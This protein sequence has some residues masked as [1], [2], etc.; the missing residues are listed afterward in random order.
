[1]NVIFTVIY[2]LSSLVALGLLYISVY[3][4]N[5]ERTIYFSFFALHTFIYIAG[6]TIEITSADIWQAILANTIQ[7][8]GIPFIAPYFLLTIC[9][10]SG[11]VIKNKVLLGS[12]FIIPVICF[13]LVATYPFNGLFY[14]ELSLTSNAGINYLSMEGSIYRTIVYLYFFVLFGIALFIASYTYIN[15]NDQIR[16]KI[17]FFITGSTI[18]LFVVVGYFLKLAPYGIDY[19]PAVLFFVLLYYGYNILFKNAFLTIP[20]A[21]DNVLD[22]MRDGYILVDSNNNY[23]DSNIVGKMIFPSL[24]EAEMGTPL[25]MLED[26]PEIIVKSNEE[27]IT[28][29]DVI[30]KDG[31]VKYYNLTKSI[32]SKQKKINLYCW[33]MHDVTERKIMMENLEFMATHDSLTKILNRNI[34]LKKSEELFENNRSEQNSIALFMLDIDF[35]KK[36]NDTYGHPNG[37]KVIV[38]V[39]DVIKNNLRAND[40]FARYGG[41]EFVVFLENVEADEAYNIGEKIRKLV[42]ENDFYLEEQKVNVTISIGICIL[43]S[44]IHKKIDDLIGEADSLL[45]EAK[46][47]GRNKVVIK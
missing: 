21:R 18:P 22:D 34:F 23:M 42:Q 40:I 41:E 17:S 36:I 45:Y 31:N 1:M 32:V 44:N 43:N 4:S 20:F 13:I 14:T 15:G 6:V 27:R 39:V 25:E 8:L 38:G 12:L 26:V 9:E 30:T 46:R 29:F 37:D 33:V 24:V 2:T 7:Y 5:E 16:K 3:K 19:T 47:S 11:I 10:Y 28:E 35:F